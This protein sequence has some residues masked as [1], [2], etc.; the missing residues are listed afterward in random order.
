MN[1]FL[2]FQ[3]AISIEQKS[4]NL[5][6]FTPDKKYSVGN[7]PNGGYLAAIMHKALVSVLPHSS[8]LIQMFGIL[9]ELTTSLWIS[10]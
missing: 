3:K 9:I 1:H 10:R 2:Q 5:F 8:Q 4:D 7:T 6:E